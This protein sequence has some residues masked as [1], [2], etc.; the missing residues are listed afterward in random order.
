MQVISNGNKKIDIIDLSIDDDENDQTNE[1]IKNDKHVTSTNYE[2]VKNRLP[3]N[4]FEISEIP[5]QKI[6][7]YC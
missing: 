4:N 3:S 2:I 6:Q 1:S 7:V 5:Q